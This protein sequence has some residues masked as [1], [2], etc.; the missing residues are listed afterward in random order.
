LGGATGEHGHEQEQ[1]NSLQKVRESIG[2]ATSDL[3]LRTEM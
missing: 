1:G 3:M 2:H